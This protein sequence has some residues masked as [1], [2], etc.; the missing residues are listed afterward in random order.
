MDSQLFTAGEL[1]QC[2]TNQDAISKEFP[3]MKFIDQRG[4]ISKKI[5]GVSEAFL[6]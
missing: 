4:Q 2:N 3:D 5:E 1:Q 6:I